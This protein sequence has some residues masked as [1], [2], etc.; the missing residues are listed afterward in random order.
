MTK[1]EPKTSTKKRINPARDAH[2]GAIRVAA[3]R[4]MGSAGR[5]RLGSRFAF[6]CLVLLVAGC[7][8]PAPPPASRQDHDVAGA[9]SPTASTFAPFDPQPTPTSNSPSPSPTPSSGSSSPPT[10]SPSAPPPSPKP[11]PPAASQAPAAPPPPPAPS[12]PIAS[13]SVLR[14]GF[15][16]AEPSIGVTKTGAIFATASTRALRSTDHGA[17]WTDASNNVPVSFDPYLWVDPGTSRI[18]HLN[19]QVATSYLSDSDDDGVRWTQVPLAGGPGDHQKL[20]TGPKSSSNPVPTIGYPNVVYYAV[21]TSLNTVVSTSFD[22][23]QTWGPQEPVYVPGLC[24]AGGINGQPHGLR[25]GT[26]LIPFYE[27]CT[28]GNWV[29]VARSTN[30]GLTWSPVPVSSKWDSGVF[31][32]DLASD[33]GG[34]TYLAYMAGEKGQHST[35]LARSSNDG[36]TWTEPIRVPPPQLGTTIFPTIVA[37]SNGRVWVSYLATDDTTKPP[38]AADASVEWY[39]YASYIPDADS[40][41]PHVFTYLVD[42]HPVQIGRISTQG[43]TG[44]SQ[45][46]NLLEFIDTALDPNTGR[47]WIVYTDGCR[48][49]TCTQKSYSTSEDVTVARLD[50]GP[51]GFEE[52]GL[53]GPP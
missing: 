45:D 28:N 46:R 11:T 49:D 8:A 52:V 2:P 34:H 26:A 30:N 9:D 38:D 40:D 31:D 16:G 7:A 50:H 17:T 37:G 32:P 44:G 47:L 53:V 21:S 27:S 13:F 24:G 19:L 10:T 35:F 42:P 29:Y 48:T 41:T 15:E 18:F 20:A 1:L 14:T 5:D 36:S 22:G 39:L 51:S 12:R 23:G 6:G 33:A 3:Q 4:S 25:T 43:T